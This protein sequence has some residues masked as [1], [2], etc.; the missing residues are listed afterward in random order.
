[1]LF[2]REDRKHVV[3]TIN[4][5]DIELTQLDGIFE[6]DGHADERPLCVLDWHVHARELSRLQSS[7]SRQCSED[8]QARLIAPILTA[9]TPNG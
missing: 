1:M 7:E 6:N 4:F 5:K 3:D 8:V 2:S 9:R